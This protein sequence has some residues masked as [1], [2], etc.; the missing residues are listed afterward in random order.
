MLKRYLL[1]G[2][3]ALLLAPVFLFAQ[4]KDSTLVDQ[5]ERPSSLTR[6]EIYV[7]GG[8]FNLVNPPLRGVTKYSSVNAGDESSVAAAILEKLESVNAFM[9]DTTKK[10]NLRLTNAEAR[11][12]YLLIS[13]AQCEIPLVPTVENIKVKLGKLFTNPAPRP[14]PPIK[15]KK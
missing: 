7:I 12:L 4:K 9:A 1:H 10:L 14:I 15:D 13:R 6:G 3:T 2:L 11:N 5:T 8:L